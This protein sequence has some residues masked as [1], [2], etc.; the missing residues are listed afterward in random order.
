MGD[1]W[2]KS[3]WGKVFHGKNN[4][5]LVFMPKKLEYDDK[6][7]QGYWYKMW[8]G[9]SF[10]YPPG[11][12]NNPASKTSTIVPLA[13]INRCKDDQL[14]ERTLHAQVCR[15]IVIVLCVRVVCRLEGFQPN[16]KLY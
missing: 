10:A 11:M 6:K 7:L 3:M 4:F 16:N 9:Y 5:P 14:I 8:Q 13:D 12:G 1:F 15:N 2:Y